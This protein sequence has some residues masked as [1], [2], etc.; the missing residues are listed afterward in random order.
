MSDHLKAAMQNAADR[1][2]TLVPC[3]TDAGL[4]RITCTCGWP[5]TLP[6]KYDVLIE[7]YAVNPYRCHPCTWEAEHDQIWPG[8]ARNKDGVRP[9]PVRRRERG[10]DER[11][12]EN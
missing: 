6:G 11:T 9:G 5:N 12:S 10:R 2:M 4:A 8:G 3:P 7:R 1:G